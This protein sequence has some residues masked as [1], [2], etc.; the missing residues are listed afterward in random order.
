MVH[1][2]MDSNVSI[3]LAQ[4]IYDKFPQFYRIDPYIPDHLET[5]FFSGFYITQVNQTL[6]EYTAI[7][8]ELL[9]NHLGHLK[10]RCTPCVP[11]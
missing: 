10:G 2:V 7:L 9:N 8:K 3:E 4:I 5:Y 1:Y 6:G 11:D